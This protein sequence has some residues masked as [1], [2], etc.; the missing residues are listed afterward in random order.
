MGKPAF[1]LGKGLYEL[2]KPYLDRG[3]VLTKN[4]HFKLM[5]PSGRSISISTTSSTDN[6]L[7]H[8]QRDLKKLEKL[9]GLRNDSNS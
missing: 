9:D 6:Y 2:L 7:G 3:W 1:K 8:V 4:K 5:A